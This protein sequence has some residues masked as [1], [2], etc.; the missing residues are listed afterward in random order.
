[1]ESSE[2]FVHEV[3]P[4][5]LEKD[6]EGI[7]RKINI[8]KPFAKSV[9]VD[10]LDGKFA[11]N[12]TFLDPRPFKKYTSELF[13]EL[14]MMVD[15]PIEYLKPWADAGFKRFLGHIE[16]MPN[17]AEFVAQGQLLGEVGL[18]IDGPTSID[19]IKVPLDD[20]DCL[21]FMTIKAG[22]SGQRFMDEHLEKLRALIS[23]DDFENLPIE[24]DGGVNDQTILEAKNA[25]ATRFITTS[26]LFG[27]V[28]PHQQYEG[29]LAKLH[30]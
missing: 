10:I 7:E 20:L 23:R 12:R 3:I 18:A 28:N 22:K 21:L 2:L 25:G 4:G 13:F 29:L 8:I 27:S 15:N 11:N 9:H 30:T 24:V 17:Q 19:E 14:H 5:I 1:M 16:N 26:Y 6:W